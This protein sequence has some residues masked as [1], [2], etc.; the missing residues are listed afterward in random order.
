MKSTLSESLDARRAGRRQAKD[1]LDER[2]H[3]SVHQL[4]RLKHEARGF[5]FLPKQ[6]INSLLSGRH[7]SRVRGRGL[8]FEEIR[9]YQAGDDIRTIDWKVTAR[10]REPFTR[11][12]TDERD[13]PALLLIFGVRPKSVSTATTVSSRR[14]RCSISVSKAD[15]ERSKTG[16]RLFFILEK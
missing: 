14:P 2:V 7:A 6:P 1:S 15:T 10:L 4:M 12:Y 5:S 16:N 13:R 11:V 3:V 8:N 9:A